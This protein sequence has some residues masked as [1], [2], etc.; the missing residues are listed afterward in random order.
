MKSMSTT[1]TAQ[2]AAIERRQRP[3]W[4][5]LILGIFAVIIGAVL[6]WAPAK[7][8]VNA[9]VLLVQL[10]GIWWLVSGILDLVVLFIDRTAWG[11][12]LFMGIISIIA[13]GYILM[14][15]IATALVLPQILVLL[16]GLWGVIHGGVLLFLAFRG[17]GWGAGIVGAIA[18]L[19]GIILIANY[20][21]PGMGLT[22]IWVAAVFGLIGGA[23]MIFQALFRDRKA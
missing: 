1:V 13:G 3:W 22:M 21:V 20:S 19:F 6:L 16:L 18:I 7:T 8:Q 5:T 4:L 9:Y 23:V 10:L 15:P 12:K 11:W 17:G 2:S 14:Y